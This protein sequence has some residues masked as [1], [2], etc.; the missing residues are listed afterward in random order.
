MRP[1]SAASVKGEETRHA[2]W[3]ELFVDLIFV[4]AVT[5]LA[6]RLTHGITAASLALLRRAL[7]ARLVVLDRHDL[8]CLPF[9]RRR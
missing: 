2:N 5:Q 4:V 9:H 8:L 1:G 7:S 6:R 3:L